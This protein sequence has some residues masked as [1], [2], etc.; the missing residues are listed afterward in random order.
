M[1]I[2]LASCGGIGAS[3]LL[4]LMHEGHDCD[5]FLIDPEPRQHK[6]LKGLVPPPLESKPNFSSYDLCIFDCTGNGDLAESIAKKTPVIGDSELASRLE[7]DRLYGI[8]IMQECG[9][10]V[11]AYE[12]F[13]NPEE[14]KAFIVEFPKRYVFK[15]F[16]VNGVEQECDTTYVSDSAED[17]LKVIDKVWH[18]S[19]EAPFLLQEVVEGVEI[20]CN[21]YFDGSFFHFVTHTLEEKKFMSGG[22]GPNTGCSGN[23]I[24][25]PEKENRLIRDGLMKL[26]P[27]LKDMG[28]R[29]PID[30]NTIVSENHAYGL[31]FT[32]RFGYDSSA[33]EWAMLDGD[34]GQFLFEIATAPEGGYID[35][36]PT[37][38]PKGRWSASERLTVPPYPEEDASFV[39]KLPIKGIDIEWAWKNCYLWDARLDGDD[40]VTVGVNGIVCCPIGVGHTPEGAWNAVDRIARPIKFPNLQTRDDLA[41]STEKR[42]KEVRAMGWID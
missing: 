22:Y 19:H 30:L 33:S 4:R 20:A 35:H 14:A 25:W 39:A 41:D 37:P 5:W 26:V 27:F 1:R 10:E 18:D 23:L 7:D 16:V 9:I 32:P 2:L 24:Y 38:K 17:L 8:Q 40:L 11:P 28:Y 12:T 34:L 3:M 29:G 42:L 31:E 15:P 6:V 36:N 21:G 13:Q